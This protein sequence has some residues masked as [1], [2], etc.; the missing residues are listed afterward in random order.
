MYR[1]L[2]LIILTVLTGC[3]TTWSHPNRSQSQTSQDLYVCQM[4]A[5]QRFPNPTP[6]SSAGMTLNQQVVS[7]GGESGAMMGAAIARLSYENN[8][9][10]AKGYK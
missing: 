7:S 10:S 1:V 2:P 4:E 9:M 8:C 3:S 6:T 5:F